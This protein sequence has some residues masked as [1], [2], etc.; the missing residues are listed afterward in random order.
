[1][2]SLSPAGCFS[3]EA[4]ARESR[5]EGLWKFTGESLGK[6]RLWGHFLLI[7]M[8][9][10]IEYF[11]YRGEPM[12]NHK[13]IGSLS[14][15]AFILLG[16]IVGGFTSVALA[17]A[18]YHWSWS[19]SPNWGAWI[20]Q[21]YYGGSSTLRWT[22][23][24]WWYSDHANAIRSNSWKGFRFEWEGYNPGN[25]TFCD[26]LDAQFV[27]S[28][29]LPNAS[30]NRYNKCGGSAYE[31]IYIWFNGGQILE[32]Q[33]YHTDT[34]WRQTGNPTS[35]EVNYSLGRNLWSSDDWLGKL[36]YGSNYSKIY[37]DPPGLT[38]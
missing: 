8:K 30:W 4:N 5:K 35:G 18:T 19:E 36:V 33:F 1:M 13:H 28:S 9:T 26:Q 34:R 21:P 25:G 3:K 23:D 15:K 7:M 37:T 32:N 2:L 10:D 24:D 22:V 11:A 6:I 20:W 12:K 14:L 16:L 29:S 17:G 31:A 27:N 38:P